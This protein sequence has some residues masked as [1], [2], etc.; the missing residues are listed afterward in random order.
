MPLDQIEMNVKLMK[1]ICNNAPFY[2]LGPLTTDIA[3]GYDHIVATIGGA[4]AAAHG[5]DFLCYVT[6]AEHLTLPDVSDVK[7]GVIASRIAAHSGDIV[8]NVKGAREHD[9]AMSK[10]RRELDW[11]GMFKYAIDPEHARSRKM[12]SESANEEYCTMCGA[13]CAVKTD[14]G[15]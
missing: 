2:V 7:E 4:I 14:S 5:V 9:Y 11:E 8:K 1:K 13:L 12:N 6:P 10:A 15:K 3:P